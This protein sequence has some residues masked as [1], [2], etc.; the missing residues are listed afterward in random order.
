MSHRRW[1]WDVSYFHSVK[2]VSCDTA[3][4]PLVAAPDTLCCPHTPR[5]TQPPA[6]PRADARAEC[7]IISMVISPKGGYQ[8]N[9]TAKDVKRNRTAMFRSKKGNVKHFRGN[10][11][12]FSYSLNWCLSSA[13]PV[14]SETIPEFSVC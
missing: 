10:F 8:P 13:K 6:Q 12:M 9:Q 7:N 11:S 3:A 14:F 2:L 4:L 5:T 1:V